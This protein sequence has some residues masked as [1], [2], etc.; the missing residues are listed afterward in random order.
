MQVKAIK[1]AKTKTDPPA[2]R[3]IFKVLSAG[4][5]DF[6]LYSKSLEAIPICLPIVYILGPVDSLLLVAWM[7]FTF[8]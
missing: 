3:A 4:G 5:S 6:P 1:I 8:F 7:R 2:M